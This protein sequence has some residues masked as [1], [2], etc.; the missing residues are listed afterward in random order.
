EKWQP[1]CVS[2]DNDHKI[3]SL[4]P[5]GEAMGKMSAAEQNELK[6]ALHNDQLR[7]GEPTF[8]E[9]QHSFNYCRDKSFCNGAHKAEFFILAIIFSSLICHFIFRL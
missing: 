8:A 6:K 1:A 7:C 3:C 5:S 4:A 9:A 2:L